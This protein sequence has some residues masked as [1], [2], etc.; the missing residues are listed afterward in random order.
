MKKQDKLKVTPI[1]SN[2]QF[3]SDI[4]ATHQQVREFVQAYLDERDMPLVVV[5]IEGTSNTRYAATLE[6][7][8]AFKPEYILAEVQEKFRV[9]AFSTRGKNMSMRFDVYVFGDK[10]EMGN[11]S[12]TNYY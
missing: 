3:S 8:Y 2:E 1:T 9:E 12:V 4:E 11:P 6:T 10:L 7:K 5:Y